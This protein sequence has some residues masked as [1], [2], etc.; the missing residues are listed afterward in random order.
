[1]P[2][3]SLSK[4][5]L[6]AK[7]RKPD[8][9]PTCWQCGQH[10][11]TDIHH[12]NGN[13]S[14]NRPG[15]LAPWCKRCHNEYHGISDNLT[16]LSIIVRQLDDIQRQR[17]AMGNRIRA[18]EALGY[19]STVAWSIHTH[20]KEI[21]G[22]VSKTVAKM[23]RQE[24]IYKV[25]LSHILGVGPQLSA[26]LVT[27]IGDPGRF[28]TIS[29]LWAY[30]GLDVENGSARRR[31]KGET[32]NW[33]QK[34]R[35]VCAKK[36]TDQFVKLQHNENCFGRALYDQY[37]TFYQERDSENLTPMHIDRRARRKVA[38]VFLSC[39]WV[40]WRRLKGLSVSEPYAAKLDHTH[41]VTPEDWAGD[42]WFEQPIQLL[43]E[44]KEKV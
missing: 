34:L 25:Y 24:P 42:D 19:E 26:D 14:D 30:C 43:L 6:R 41:F 20:L 37:K 23:V 28:G 33:N 11:A 44:E 38:K 10:P 8:T 3:N 12:L 7:L 16:V 27:E 21:E 18:Y 39:L 5:D 40:A 31:R 1:M 32:A 15:N 13:H 29:A 35:S 17:I 9:R 36:L 4:T 22:D 2:I